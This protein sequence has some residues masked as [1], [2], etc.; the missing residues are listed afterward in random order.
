LT[1]TLHRFDSIK[2]KEGCQYII[3]F[4]DVIKQVRR[5]WLVYV[6]LY[7]LSC[8]GRELYDK[9]EQ[10]VE[11]LMITIDNY[12]KKRKRTHM[13]M[14]RVWSSEEPHP[15]EEVCINIYSYA[16]TKSVILI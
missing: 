16:I 15:Q 12:M 5:D 13:G 9:K 4:F 11:R 6:I 2:L 7:C 3:S 8:V 1:S 14:L 10:T